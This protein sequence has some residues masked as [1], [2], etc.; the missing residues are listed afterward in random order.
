MEKKREV[1]RHSTEYKS[2][3]HTAN[4]S[5]TKFLLT[6]L[7]RQ[8]SKIHNSSASID[9]TQTACNLGF[10][11]DEH[12]SFSD[13]ISALSKS[14]YHCICALCSIHPYLD[15]HT[16]KTIATSIVHSKLDC[17]NSLYYGLSIYQINRL[18]HIQNCC[19]GSQF[20]KKP[21]IFLSL[22]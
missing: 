11:F 16:T 6:G 2:S 15:L 17:C 22:S 3:R 12:L 10:I 18:Q 4:F 14:F 19:P 20:T 8:L 9:T 1:E 5:N 13:Q 7:K 21:K